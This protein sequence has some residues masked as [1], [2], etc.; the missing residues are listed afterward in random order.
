[1][2]KVATTDN[3]TGKETER[4][5]T[6]WGMGA[7]LN[8]TP[9]ALFAGIMRAQSR[10]ED[11]VVIR[12]VQGV[13]TRQEAAAI[14]AQLLLEPRRC[15]PDPQFFLPGSGMVYLIGDPIHLLEGTSLDRAL[16][17]GRQLS[18]PSVFE[19]GDDL[20]RGVAPLDED[21]EPYDAAAF[22]LPVVS[23]SQ[24]RDRAPI[25]M[26]TVLFALPNH[27]AGTRRQY[28]ELDRDDKHIC[29]SGYLAVIP[30]ACSR[31]DVPDFVVADSFGEQVNIPCYSQQGYICIGNRC[32]VA[33]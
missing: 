5:V 24:G 11:R 2:Y 15:S 3:S 25:M 20:D 29:D 30:R 22:N 21:L 9:K 7:L 16:A 31:P 4:T 14:L 1:M 23:Q 26:R 27:T 28:C 12:S 8:G 32:I 6:F 18:A 33:E 13:G 17:V 19:H 10:D